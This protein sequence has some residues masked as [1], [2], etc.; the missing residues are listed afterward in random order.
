[1]SFSGLLKQSLCSTGCLW[2]GQLQINA[3][4]VWMTPRQNTILVVKEGRSIDIHLK[5]EMSLLTVVRRYFLAFDHLVATEEVQGAVDTEGLQ[6]IVEET[7]AEEASEG[8]SDP[9]TVTEE[10]ELVQAADEMHETI[11]DIDSAAR[12]MLRYAQGKI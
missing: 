6:D 7:K 8:R 11:G 4:T 12:Q 10:D 9:T 2:T 5:M 3:S 1:M